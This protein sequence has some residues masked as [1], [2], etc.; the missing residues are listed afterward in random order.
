MRSEIDLQMNYPQYY[1][2]TGRTGLERTEGKMSDYWRIPA[3]SG[4]QF[5]KKYLWVRS[6]QL[7][8]LFIKNIA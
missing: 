7:I 8:I 3:N 2:E 6:I 1:E 4:R 5:F